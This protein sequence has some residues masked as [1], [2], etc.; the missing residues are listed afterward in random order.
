L[1][2]YSCCAVL[3][4]LVLVLM[5][6]A[7]CCARTPKWRRESGRAVLGVLV[8][9][10]VLLAICGVGGDCCRSRI[11]CEVGVRRGGAHLRT[12]TRRRAWGQG[13]TSGRRRRERKA[14]VQE[15]VAR[16][17]ARCEQEKNWK[18]GDR[19]SCAVVRRVRMCARAS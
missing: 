17:R 7:C 8:L 5:Q 2:F 12:D 3:G 15:R 1:L 11:A 13:R 9:V 18:R 19:A 10:L 4:V 16:E 6:L 14:G